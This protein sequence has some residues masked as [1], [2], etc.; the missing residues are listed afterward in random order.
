MRTRKKELEAIADVLEQ[1]H[2]DVVYL[3]EII[4][5]MIDDMR[6]DRELYVVGV[7]YQGVGQFLFGAY[8]SETMAIKD[9][10]GRG[11]I[12][13]LKQGDVARVFKLLAPTKVFADTDEIQGDLFDMR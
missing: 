3:A 2:H 10:E 9:Y 7:N 4:W 1:E 6:R 5:K 8:E 13:A 11:N 12:R